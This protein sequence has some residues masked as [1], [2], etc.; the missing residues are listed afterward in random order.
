MATELQR[1]TNEKNYIARYSA[2]SRPRMQ[3]LGVMFARHRVPLCCAAEDK[4]DLSHFIEQICLIAKRGSSHAKLRA[5]L[6]VTPSH[7]RLYL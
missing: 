2:L 7:R 1:A 3:C 5:L 6:H 4:V